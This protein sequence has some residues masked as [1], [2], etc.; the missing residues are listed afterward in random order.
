[1]S[2]EIEIIEKEEELTTDDEGLLVPRVIKPVLRAPKGTNGDRKKQDLTW[3]YYIKSWRAG[4][5]SAY[6]AAIAAGYAHNTAINI[7]ANKWFKEKRDKLKRSRMLTKAEANL[8]RI[9]NLDYSRMKLVD[10]GAKDE[11]G[12]P[13]MSKEESVDRDVLKVVADVSKMIVT[14][15]GKDVGYSTKT[16]VSG[17]QETEIKVNTI[18]YA[19]EPIKTEITIVEE[20]PNE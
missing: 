6:K 1:M 19:Q 7:T 4:E 17:K 16:E 13:I 20:K 5:P 12:N 3:E 10:S 14:N 11:E 9:M 8:S 15:L 18:S 2:E